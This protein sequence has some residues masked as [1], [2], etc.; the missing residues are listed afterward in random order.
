[1]ASNPELD[2]LLA[3][4]DVLYSRV[5]AVLATLP[6]DVLETNRSP[7]RREAP[8]LTIAPGSGSLSTTRQLM[9]GVRVRAYGGTVKDDGVFERTARLTRVVTRALRGGEYMFLRDWTDAREE[10]MNEDSPTISWVFQEIRIV[11]PG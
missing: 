8:F 4:A 1:M 7:S 9:D 3:A 2:T 6:L 10:P 5:Q 11:E